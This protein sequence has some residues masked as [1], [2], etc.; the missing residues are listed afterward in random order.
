MYSVKPGRG[1]S[2]MG[3]FAGIVAAVFGVIW[4]LIAGSIGAPPIIRL[5]GVLFV[6]L[7]IGS[8]IYNLINATRR[9]R[10]STFDITTG[11]EEQDPLTRLIRN[12]ETTREDTGGSSRPKSSGSAGT[13][14][15]P[16]KFCPFCGVEVHEDFDFCPTCGKDI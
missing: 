2:L 7:A 1:P 8:S 5:F 14:K 13:R 15:Y 4:I 9:D 10:M 12:S 6:I 16:G 3:G 11:S